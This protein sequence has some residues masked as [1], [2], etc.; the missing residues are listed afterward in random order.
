MAGFFTN[1]DCHFHTILQDFWPIGI[2]LS[3]GYPRIF[4]NRDCPIHAMYMIMNLLMRIR[5]MDVLLSSLPYNGDSPIR[6]QVKEK[7]DAATGTVW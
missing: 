3:M 7:R 6:S 5:Y 2:A 1:R 4:H